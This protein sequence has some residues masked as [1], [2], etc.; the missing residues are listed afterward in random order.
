MRYLSSCIRAVDS[1]NRQQSSIALFLHGDPKDWD[2]DY[3]E[4]RDRVL[5]WAISEKIKVKIANSFHPEALGED[6]KEELGVVVR[7]LA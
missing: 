1:S 2:L 6:Q 3:P 4:F 7:C 5:T